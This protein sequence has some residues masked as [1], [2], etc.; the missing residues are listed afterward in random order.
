MVVKECGPLIKATRVRGVAK[1]KQLEIQLMAKLVAKCAYECAERSD[2]LPDRRPHP[3]TG[4][5]FPD[6]SLKKLGTPTTLIHA[7]GS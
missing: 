6:H 5:V 7:E 3:D 2:L 4:N 1:V